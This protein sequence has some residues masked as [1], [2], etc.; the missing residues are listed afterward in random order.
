MKEKRKIEINK[1]KNQL[2]LYGY[3]SHFH[4]FKSLYEKKELP[5]TI[6]L[7]GKKGIGK[8]T[9]A[10]HFINFILS[11][12]EKKE[13]SLKDLVI[14]N[15]NSTYNLIQNNTHPN[16]Y[17]LDKKQSEEIKIDQ[18]RD[19]IKF[20]SKTAY[21][22]G[23]KIVLIDNAENLNLNASNSL[24]KSIEEPSANT[25]FFIIDNDSKKLMKTITSRCVNFK[26]HFSQ[27][28]KS[29]VFNKLIN[30]YDIEVNEKDLDYFLNFDTHGN[31]LKYLL[32]LKEEDISISKDLLSCACYFINQ[33]KINSDPNILNFIMLFIEKFYHQLSLTNSILI[34]K[35][36]RNRDKII[37]LI[38]N[39]KKFNLDKKNTLFVINNIIINETR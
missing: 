19:L 16:F 6:L 30:A 3:E 7:S 18:T 35:Y 37:N 8:A 17:L 20:L 5:N 36:T 10:Y 22:K 26:I 1:A 27:I 28:D 9:F 11:R 39:M 29:N 15:K 24:L 25:F 38:N 14:N 21:Y 2:N 4:I 31:I 13:Y 32:M 33:Y 34:N 23:V 12:D